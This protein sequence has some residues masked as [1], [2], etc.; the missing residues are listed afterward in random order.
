MP[1]MNSLD[2]LGGTPITQEPVK[3][4]LVVAAAL[5]PRTLI[6]FVLDETGSMLSMKGEVISGF[7]KYREDLLA[8]ENLYRLSLLKFDSVGLRWVVHSVL[9]EATVPLTAQTYQPGAS[10]PLYDAVYAAI[11]DAEAWV[12][13]GQKCITVIFT[14]GQENC[15]FRHT[16][17]QVKAKI[18]EKEQ[19]GWAFIYMGVAPEAWTG[20]QAMFAGTASM[21]NKFRSAGAQ[22]MSASM[23]YGTHS[24]QVYAST[25]QQNLAD[26]AAQQ[27]ADDDLKRQQGQQ[28]K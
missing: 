22:G 1:D 17:E 24:T 10:T 2:V 28:Q 26:D 14:D 27:K 6:N 12:A 9:L 21:S 25:G 7:N 19:A 4:E 3:P 18:L 15:S 23:D 13:P 16:A 8:D 20:D 11:E 5:K